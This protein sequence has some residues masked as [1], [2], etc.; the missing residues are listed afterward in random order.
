MGFNSQQ[1]IDSHVPFFA[2]ETRKRVFAS[3][4][5]RDKSLATYLG[6]PSLIHRFQCDFAMPLDLEDSD[7]FLTGQDLDTAI[8]SLDSDGWNL[9]PFSNGYLRPATVIRIRYR[10]SIL[11][12][13]VL[14]LS[15]GQRK[16][17]FPEELRY[18]SLHAFP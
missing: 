13:N 8:R 12:E 9:T 6:R 16:E 3:V 7:L 5:R 10:T 14:D 2:S 17:G 11:R 18:V 1:K 4:V 15:L